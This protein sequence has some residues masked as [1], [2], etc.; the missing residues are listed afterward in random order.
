MI[1]IPIGLAVA[2]M[3][4]WLMHKYVLHGRGKKRGSFWSF[5]WHEHHKEARQKEMIDPFYQ[6]SVLGWHGQGKE[7]LA[8]VVTG[9]VHAPLLP[10]APF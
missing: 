6:R 8:L 10:V 4:E 1:G 9:L 3:S 5:Y 2:N 7:A